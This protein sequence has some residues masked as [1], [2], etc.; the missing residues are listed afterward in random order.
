MIPRGHGMLR[1]AAVQHKP[2]WKLQVI[3]TGT[4]PVIPLRSTD[5]G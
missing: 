5:N 4:A 2:R 1:R 3:E